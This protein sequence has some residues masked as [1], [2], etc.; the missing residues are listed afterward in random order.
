M[1]FTASFDVTR[2]VTASLSDDE[3]SAIQAEVAS[4]FDV[5][6]DEVSTT[7][8]Y[9]A[10]GSMTIDAA[11][12]SEE[13]VIEAIESALVDELKV[14]PSD[15]EV[16]YDPETGVVSYV[17]TSDDIAF[18]DNAI[19]TISQDDFV[20]ELDL[21]D[22]ITIDS[23]LPPADIVVTVDVVVDASNVDDASI[24][25]NDVTEAIQD[26]EPSYNVIGRVSFRTSAPTLQP[27]TN[28]S[29][30]P[31]T[32]VPSTAPS[33]TGWIATVSA[34]T[35]ATS[36]MS[37]SAIN[38][39]ATSVAEFYG[40]EPSDVAVSTAYESTGSLTLTIP[41]ELSED[42]LTLGSSLEGTVES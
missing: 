14:H 29:I 18:V 24:A 28:P 11:E 33:M 41:D 25:V 19:T 26:Q 31:S 27:S 17:I 7:V 37:T 1:T 16:A 15:I 2:P 3:I 30:S 34:S 12:L 36:E 6:S 39:Y 22:D 20:V 8:S 13:E 21:I 10:S 35:I 4:N 32:T 5:S 40:V 23:V 42:E 38:D 9:S